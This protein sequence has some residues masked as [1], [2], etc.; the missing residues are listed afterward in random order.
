[1]NVPLEMQC[2]QSVDAA[3]FEVRVP[4][5][6]V[7]TSAAVLLQRPEPTLLDTY[8]LSPWMV[9]AVVDVASA[10][11][12]ESPLRGQ[13]IL[14]FHYRIS[15]AIE[16]AGSWGECRVFEPAC[17]LWF[18]PNGCDDVSERLGE[19]LRVPRNV[20]QPVVAIACGWIK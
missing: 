15:G 10:E 12:F 14:E 13:N 5:S 4:L 9:M 3:L 7:P 17:L 19:A 20:G 2:L 6:G 8:Y 16:L 18:Q 1:M 11:R